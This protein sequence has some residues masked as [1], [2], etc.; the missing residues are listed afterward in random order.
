ML[1]IYPLLLN[2]NVQMVTG[3]FNMALLLALMQ[4]KDVKI[5]GYSQ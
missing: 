3:V 2:L 5:T 1:V 4:L